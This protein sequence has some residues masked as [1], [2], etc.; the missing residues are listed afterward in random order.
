VQLGEGVDQVERQRAPAI[1]VERV[2]GQP[3]RKPVPDDVA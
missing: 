2:V 3:L 1:G